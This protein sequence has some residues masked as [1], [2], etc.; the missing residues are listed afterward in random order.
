MVPLVTPVCFLANPSLQSFVPP[1]QKQR[2][3]ALEPG[4][5]LIAGGDP[6]PGSREPHLQAILQGLEVRAGGPALPPLPGLVPHWLLSQHTG[7]FWMLSKGDTFRSAL[8]PWD[9]PWPDFCPTCSLGFSPLLG[10]EEITGDNSEAFRSPALPLHDQDSQG[11]CCSTPHAQK[12]PI[13]GG[14]VPGLSIAF[15]PGFSPSLTFPVGTR[16]WL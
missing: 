14:T 12:N 4:F 9:L 1:P 13:G 5:S 6:A 7:A 2:W 16:L 8:F 11:S 3:A 10:F 15:R